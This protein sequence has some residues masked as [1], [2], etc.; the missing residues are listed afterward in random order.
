MSESEQNGQ[1]EPAGECARAAVEGPPA[2]GAWLGQALQP[3]TGQ[4]RLEWQQSCSNQTGKL[5]TCSPTSRCAEVQENV[6]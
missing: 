5:L 6:T 2:L 4:L 1:V 3:D